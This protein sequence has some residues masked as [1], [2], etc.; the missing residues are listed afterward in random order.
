MAVVILAKHDADEVIVFVDNGERVELVLPDDVV[1][2]FKGDVLVAHDELLTR[3]HEGLDLGLVVIATGT[4]IAARDDSE[5]FAARGAV[6]RDGH[7]G[8]T[9]LVF[10]LHDLFHG[11]I[12]RQ[13]RVGLDEAGFMVLDG[14]DHGGLG[15][16][17]LYDQFVVYGQKSR[18]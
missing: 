5:Q 1:C 9:R 13:R 4:V 14:L 7:G 12:R 18:R 3:R 17:G 8:V 10:E 15:L 11:H 2:L 6:V 16:G